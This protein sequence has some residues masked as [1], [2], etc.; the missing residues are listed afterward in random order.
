MNKFL[1]ILILPILTYAKTIDFKTAFKT[2]LT[3]NKELKAKKLSITKAQVELK[4]VDGYKLGKMEFNENISRTNHSGYVFGAKLASREATFGDFGFDEFLAPMGQ[5]LMIADDG[6]AGN[7]DPSSMSSIL[8][9]K[10]QKLNNPEARNHFETKLT[11]EIPI[12]T[13]FKLQSAKQMAKLQL[14]AKKAKYTYD[15]KK[16]G[17][18]V[19]KAYNGAV[20]AKHFIA[21]TLKAKKATTSFVNFANELYNEGLV[22][23]IDVKQA[24]VYDMGVDA[25]VIDAKNRFELAIAYL[26]FLTDDKSIDDV[27]EFEDIKFNYSSIKSLQETAITNRDDYNWMKYNTD[28]MKEKIKFDSAEKYPMVGA[29]LEYGYNDDS[30]NN[31]NSNHDYYV[32]AIGLKYTIFDGARISMAKQKATIE[33]QKTKH[34]FEHMREGIK[35]EVEKNLLMLK[36]KEKILKQKIKAQNL[37]E[38]VLDQSQ[39]M[40]KNHLINMNNL[41]MQQANAQKSRAETILSKYEKT[42][43]AANLKIS[44][45]EAL[46]K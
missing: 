10:P 41:L 35:L 27:S 3:N 42:L 18:E 39:E 28:T 46:N 34:Y 17:L 9:T 24:Q 19:L 13:G 37:A 22:T 32:M 45:G 21:A 14:Q 29:H 4:E 30:L 2:V 38:E 43:A 5:A 8:T 11:Y 26:R 44:L 6:T 7:L 40:Y 1:I 16:L 15:E 20:A 12:F 31:I 25:K 36:T 23:A 33:Y